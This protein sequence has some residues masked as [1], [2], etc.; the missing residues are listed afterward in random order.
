MPAAPTPTPDQLL[1][2]STLFARKRPD[3]KILISIHPPS[4]KKPLP[5]KETIYCDTPVE[6]AGVAAE[7]ST[8]WHVFYGVVPRRILGRDS[9]ST[10]G[11]TALWVDLDMP[12]EKAFENLRHLLLPPTIAIRSGNGVQ[13]LW[14]LWESPES[15]AVG[16][17]V[18]AKLHAKLGAV[19][20]E[21]SDAARLLR[22]PGTQNVKKADNPKPCV[23]EWCDPE[24]VYSV[25]DIRAAIDVP[26]VVRTMV[27]TGSNEGRKSRSERDYYVLRTLLKHG[28]S[29]AAIRSVMR[30]PDHEISRKLDEYAD[31]DARLGNELESALAEVQQDLA[32]EEIKSPAYFTQEKDGIYYD[33]RRLSTFTIEPVRKIESAGGDSLVCRVTAGSRTWN[34]HIIKKS[35]FTSD[36]HLVKA[37]PMM[38][39]QWFGTKREARMFGIWLARRANELGVPSAIAV[40]S[41]GL[42][43]RFYISANQVLGEEGLIPIEECEYVLADAARAP[44]DYHHTDWHITSR[45]HF[46][47]LMQELCPLLTDV[48]K[49]HI[50][51]PMIGWY[52]VAPLKPVLNKVVDGFPILNMYGTNG[53]GKTTLSRI[54]H[55]LF[56]I[57]NAKG[58]D[59]GADCKT[60]RFSLVKI[61]SSTNALPVRFSEHRLG[62]HGRHSDLY[63]YVR[64]LWDRM[65][66]PRGRRDMTLHR[67]V[68]D[69]PSSIDGEDPMEDGAIKE[70]VLRIWVCKEHIEPGTVYHTRMGQVEALPLEDFSYHYF[71][72]CL[73]QRDPALIERR[74]KEARQFVRDTFRR[75]IPNRIII[76]LAITILGMRLFTEFA[77]QF[78]VNV[79]LSVATIKSV[80][81]PMLDELLGKLHRVEIFCDR[82]VVDIVNKVAECKSYHTTPPFTYK[83][84]PNEKILWYNFPAAFDW[85]T[86]NMVKKQQEAIGNRAI[87]RQLKEQAR[88]YAV[89]GKTH[90]V[91]GI[92]FTLDGIR[93]ERANDLGLEVPRDLGYDKHEEAIK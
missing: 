69:A 63:R 26:K 54:F 91:R 35:D 93:L 88:E 8:G 51:W 66:D 3:E 43:G 10:G 37:F 52:M 25:A 23:L 31:P 1:F 71:L 27:L 32:A 86:Q 42:H 48:N 59:Y 67:Y 15:I 58:G 21:T 85:W 83:Y 55:R 61:M 64:L 45:D 70:R 68:L 41:T 89:E 87:R 36:D 46:E 12:P 78:G 7:W 73:S 17:A 79:P 65:D 77:V 39:C 18:E 84:D 16:E 47:K 5:L 11:W 80:F 2:F 44:E 30:N 34:N 24:R 81:E 14:C 57:H 75:P 90:R 62:D 72:F 60:T 82:Y 74:F 19:P 92:P 40:D 20:H 22:V 28:M 4:E 9:D 53:S 6:A 33:G 29:Q 13:A 56:T 50:I 76:T 49:P 38:D